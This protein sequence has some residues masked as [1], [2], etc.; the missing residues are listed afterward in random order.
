MI[1]AHLWNRVHSKAEE[2]PVCGKRFGYKRIMLAH[3]MVH[4]GPQ[5]KCSFCGKMFKQKVTLVAHEAEHTGEKPF[6]CT[7]CG[8]S[9]SWKGALS[10]HKRLVHKIAGSRARPSQREKERGVTGFHQENTQ[11][12]D[13]ADD[14]KPTS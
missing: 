14:V 12:P 3:M 11:K 10:Q 9:F 13:I 1:C 8:K 5:F 2:C 4:M 7:L 6:E